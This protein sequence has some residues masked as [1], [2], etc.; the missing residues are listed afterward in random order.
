MRQRWVCRLNFLHE[1][2]SC[3]RELLMRERMLY[4]HGVHAGGIAES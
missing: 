1:N 2:S 3:S 4:I